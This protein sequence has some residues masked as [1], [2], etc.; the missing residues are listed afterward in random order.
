MRRQLSHALSYTGSLFRSF[1]SFA[2]V[3]WLS[4]FH[5]FFLVTSI[6]FDF[7]INILL[8]NPHTRL[9]Y[10]NA[11]HFC[12]F[13]WF[14]RWCCLFCCWHFLI[15]FVS[16]NTFPF[17]HFVPLVIP[18]QLTWWYFRSSF[19]IN[20]HYWVNNS[21]RSTISIAVILLLVFPVFPY[22]Q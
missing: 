16:N 9:I 19:P 10:T 8:F 22:C 6:P 12:R 21:N 11:T 14:D 1:H 7:N 5:S 17:W 4:L 18:L 3:L 15:V 20:K 2:S 13:K